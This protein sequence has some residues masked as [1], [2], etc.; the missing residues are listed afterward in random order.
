[1]SGKYSC[2]ECDK[3]FTARSTLNGHLAS[4][5]LGERSVCDACQKV[6]TDKSNFRRHRKTCSGNAGL[7]RCAWHQLG[8]NH[9]S[10]RVDNVKRHVRSC[11]HKPI[12]WAGEFPAPI[13][14]GLV[15]SGQVPD[16]G[17]PQTSGQQQLPQ[18]ASALAQG[19]AVTP[20][21]GVDASQ[22][23]IDLALGDPTD[24]V[25]F[26]ANFPQFDGYWGQDVPQQA[27]GAGPQYPAALPATGG[28]Q[29][30]IGTGWNAVDNGLFTG[31]GTGGDTFLTNAPA[32]ASDFTGFF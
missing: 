7:Y 4:V 21:M 32:L 19:P 8:C 5:H 30:G 6:F 3:S 9:T 31:Y 14:A 12:A 13:R 25:W 24:P 18:D 16:N 26:A 11:P 20:T 22:Q 28:F 1:M 15:Q 10:N 27:P 2:T 17:T 23:G 29:Q